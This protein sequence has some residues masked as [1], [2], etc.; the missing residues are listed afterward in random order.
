MTARINRTLT[1]IR[2][3]ALTQ[4]MLRITLGGENLRG[5]PE[6]QE[7]GYIKLMFSPEGATDVSDILNKGN[8]PV[9]RSYTIRRFDSQSL[10]MD[11]DVVAHG[12]NG[13]ASR[14]AQSC[15]P[16]SQI[17]IN[18]PGAK[19]LVDMNAD[20]FFLAGDMTALPAMSV[21]LEQL[22]DNARGYAVIEVISP[23][24][25]QSLTAPEH[26]EIHW[27]INPHPDRPN[28]L[29]PNAVKARPWLQGQANIWLACEFDTMRALRHYFKQTRELAPEAMYASSYWKMGE[30]DEGHKA[31]KKLDLA[32]L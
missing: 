15:Q 18:G 16:G 22:P 8:K 28:Q 19:K 29:L 25:Q 27:V 11:I 13:P 26:M 5:F 12:D 24:D 30:T 31:A 10:A 14:W 32:A 23:E 4:N 9:L 17:T 20:W 21:N 3:R 7:S 1:V 6:A 2:K